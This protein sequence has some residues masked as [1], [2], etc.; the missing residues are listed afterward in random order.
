VSSARKFYISM[1]LYWMGF[2]LGC[3]FYPAM[4]KLFMTPAGKA[5]TTPYSDHVWLHGGMDIL[6]VTLLL[7]ALSTIPATKT[8]LRV[9]ATVGL[10][11]TAA[12][13]YGVATG[14]YWSPVFL[15]PAAGCLAFAVWGFVLARRIVAGGVS[16]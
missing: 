1:G 13:I 2:G 15:V 3:T 10:L 16:H 9:A 6:S 11:P 12:M 4:M 8:T 14:L 5:A 7:F